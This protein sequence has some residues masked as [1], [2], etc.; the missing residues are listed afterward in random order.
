MVIG[1]QDGMWV[2]DQDNIYFLRGQIA[3]DLEEFPQ[4]IKMAEYPAIEG[5]EVEAPMDDFPFNNLFGMGYI[6]AASQGICLLGPNGQF[7]NLTKDR[8]V[9]PA[10]RYGAGIYIDGKYVVMIEP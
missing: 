5:T 1:V 3:P 8:L 9:L 4:L 2:S 7:I 10:M 6:V